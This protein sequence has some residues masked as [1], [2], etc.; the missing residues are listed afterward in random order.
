MFLNDFLGLLLHVLQCFTE[1]R[2]FEHRPIGG[3]YTS[4]S[5]PVQPGQPGQGPGRSKPGLDGRVACD[6]GGLP[7]GRGDRGS[8]LAEMA[9]WKWRMMEIGIIN[10]YHGWDYRGK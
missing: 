10:D 4:P 6:P 5:R 2:G 3:R 8:C 1:I 7:R 9:K